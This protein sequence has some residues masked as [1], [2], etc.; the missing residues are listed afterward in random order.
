MKTWNLINLYILML[1]EMLTLAI[2]EIKIYQENTGGVTIGYTSD[3]KQ[4]VRDIYRDWE[5][6][7]KN[8][9]TNPTTIT[10]TITN[11]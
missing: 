5:T 1:V 9:K 8:L 11:Q 6:E 4:V 10:N 2:P 3:K 7:N